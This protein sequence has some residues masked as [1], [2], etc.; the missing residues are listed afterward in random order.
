MNERYKNVVSRFLAWLPDD[1]IER[2]IDDAINLV[3]MLLEENN[4][5]IEEEEPYATYNIRQNNFA[6][7]ALSSLEYEMFYD[8]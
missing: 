5:R 4:R 7:E 6:L 8:D 2:E 3:R 1:A